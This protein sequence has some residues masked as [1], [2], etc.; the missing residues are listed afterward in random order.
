MSE[1]KSLGRYEIRGVLG[2]GAM[3]LVYDGHDATL[4]RRVAIKTILTRNLDEATAKHYEMRFRREVRAV[5][6]LNHPNI[7]QV[8]DFGTEGD[9]AYIVMEYIQGR[10]L[11]D[12]LDAKE[13]L[14]LGKIF[15]LMGELL[16]ALDF[17]HE[18]GVIHRD[19][20]PANVMI[21]TAGHAKLADFGVARVTEAGGDQGEATR[22]GAMVGTPSYMSPEQIQGQTIDR[23]TDIFSA[24]ILFYQLLTGQKPFDGTGFA[25]AKKIVQDDPVWPTKLV[26]IPPVIDGVIQRALAKAADERY[27]TARAFG[28]D[29]KLILEGRPPKEAAKPAKSA[30][31]SK[32]GGEADKEFWEEVK[33]SADPDEIELYLEQFP[34][35]T[36]AEEAQKKLAALRAKKG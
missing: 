27:Q 15:T 22:A 19:I 3:G 16:D 5:A 13:G 20:K 14:E 1:L 30:S 31:H 26:Q 17:A 4:D 7:V 23:R 36:F 21:D 6:R 29:L 8:Y 25:L 35:G 33:N 18:A 32:A 34:D 2:K 28:G 11:K 10:E 9:L 12:M 24:G